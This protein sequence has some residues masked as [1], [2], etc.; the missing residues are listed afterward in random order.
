LEPLT[1][2]PRGPFDLR[3]AIGFGFGPTR[4]GGDEVLR[5]AFAADGTGAPIGAELRQAERDG[6][7]IALA[8]GE[9]APA[10]VAAQ[11]ARILS[12]DADGEA[13]AALGAGDPVL[14]G[15]QARFAGLRPVLF[16]SPYEAACWAII[17]AR[18][19]RAQAARASDAIAVAHGHGFKLAGEVRHAWPAPTRLLAAL[20]DDRLSGL[21]GEKLRRLHG[22]ATAAAAG[23]LDAARLHALGPE[24]AEDAVGALRGFGPFYRSLVVVRAVG[25]TDA[26]PADEPRARRSAAQLHGLREL[27]AERFTAL[28]ESWRPFR[29]WATVLLR[30]GAERDG[31]A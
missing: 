11:L 30:V 28:A 2:R 7:M 31:L 25:F 18:W 12:L 22:V 14:G 13:W 4:A 19:G 20:D 5:L 29:T 16:H 17:S 23:E 3:Q 6:P 8:R 26:F 24:A 1:L 10:A 27:D 9:A 15:L 21:P